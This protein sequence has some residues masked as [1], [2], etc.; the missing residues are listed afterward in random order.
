MG[1]PI[2][3]FFASKNDLDMWQ[4]PYRSQYFRNELPDEIKNAPGL[5][6]EFKGQTL[7]RPPCP[8]CDSVD[9]QS[10]GI[11]WHCKSCGRYY[12]K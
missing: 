4:L 12:K 8:T 3:R 11:Q 2:V 1:A 5:T 7:E 10:R 6:A 9:I